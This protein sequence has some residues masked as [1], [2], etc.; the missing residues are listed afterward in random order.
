[1]NQQS[2]TRIKLAVRRA[3]RALD[4]HYSGEEP[5]QEPQGPIGIEPVKPPKELS[6]M[7]NWS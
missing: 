6:T 5:T 2:R 7:S 1:M 4:L 3:K